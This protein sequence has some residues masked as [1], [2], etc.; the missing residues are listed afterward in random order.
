VRIGTIPAA[1]LPYLLNPDGQSCYGR[2]NG[3]DIALP[4]SGGP[5]IDPVYL[6][7]VGHPAIGT[8]AGKPSFLA[9]AAGVVRAGDVVL[10]EYQNG[11]DYLAAWDTA[12]GQVAPGWPAQVNDLQ[13]L[14]GPSL[15]NIDGVPGQEVFGGTASDDLQGLSGAGAPIDASWPKLTG[16]WTVSIPAIGAW[17][18]GKTK[19]LVSGVRDGRLMAYDTGAGLC[20]DADWPQFHHDPANSGDARRDAIAP[21][22][23]TEAAGDDRKLTFKATGDDLGCGTAKKY[24]VTTSARPIEDFADGTPVTTKAAPKAAGTKDTI[25]LEGDI[26]RYVALRAVDE[27][28]NAGRFVR[29]DRVTGA[30]VADGADAGRVAARCRKDRKRPRSRIK[31][32]RLRRT[33]GVLVRGRT[34]D[35]GCARIRAVKVSVVRSGHKARFRKAHGK[36][37]WRLRRKHRLAAGRYV[38][39]VRAK[40]TRGNV[41]KRARRNRRLVVVR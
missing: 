11:R 14:T 27:Q 7:A 16:D 22:H 23:V 24:E 4:T 38:V 30:V 9:P 21:G 12:T 25:T 32:V 29:F 36:S 6:A 18:A 33:S 10:P 17:G 40:D 2:S 39:R 1:G 34:V 31:R 37:R 28:G 26:D 20:A 8:L 3:K 13:F 5:A 35:P 19:V 15:A 41:E